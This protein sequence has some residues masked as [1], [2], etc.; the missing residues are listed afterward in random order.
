MAELPHLV[1]G[2]GKVLKPLAEARQ[3]AERIC[4]LVANERW[5]SPKGSLA[6]TLSIGV[7]EFAE[8]DVHTA[9][10]LIDLADKVLYQSKDEGRNRVC[11]YGK[12]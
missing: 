1:V 2:W 7:A 11:V 5:E 4:S 10:Q 3:T 8:G 6:V 9:Q 12:E